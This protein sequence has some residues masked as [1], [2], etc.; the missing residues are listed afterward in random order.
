MDNVDRQLN[1]GIGAEE[2]YLVLQNSTSVSQL[3][4]RYKYRCKG[5]DTHAELENESYKPVHSRQIFMNSNQLL[6]LAT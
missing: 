2:S 4:H 5:I 6:L 3:I 1:L